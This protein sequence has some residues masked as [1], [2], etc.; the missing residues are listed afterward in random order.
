MLRFFEPDQN[1]N[2][3]S[4]LKVG[5][6]GMAGKP[7][8][9]ATQTR[10]KML[11]YPLIFKNYYVVIPPHKSSRPPEFFPFGEQWIFCPNH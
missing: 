2:R 9:F 5:A 3:R 8:C 1:H 4:F 11:G 7:F 6:M 10:D